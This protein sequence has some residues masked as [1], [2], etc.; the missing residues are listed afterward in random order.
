MEKLNIAELL[1]DCPSGMELDC[2]M[3]DNVKLD[4]VLEVLTLEENFEYVGDD[5]NHTAL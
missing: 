5:K 1:K 4:Y 3:Y 2:P